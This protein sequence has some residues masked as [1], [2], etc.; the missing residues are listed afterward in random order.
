M[1]VTLP[2]NSLDAQRIGQ[3]LQN[4]ADRRMGKGNQKIGTFCHQLDIQD[5]VKDEALL[6]YKNIAK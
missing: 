5:R 4:N 6:I 2:G 1:G 3:Q